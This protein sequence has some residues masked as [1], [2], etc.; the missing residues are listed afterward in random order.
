MAA[1]RI[2]HQDIE[3]IISICLREPGPRGR[4]DAALFAIV[5]CGK[6]SIPE[7]VRCGVEQAKRAVTAC[8]PAFVL[9]V[10]S[11]LEIRP[12]ADGP[13]LETIDR[14]G[15]LLAEPMAATTASEIIRRRAAEA[16]IGYVTPQE[17]L[18]ASLL[19]NRPSIAPHHPDAIGSSDPPC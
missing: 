11:W 10:N 16:R 19:V 5:W 1:T 7:A 4:R 14:R 6:L 12:P 17:L 8:S 15:R 18:R 2:T 9:A 13:L 3:E